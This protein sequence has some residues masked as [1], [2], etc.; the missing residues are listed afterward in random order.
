MLEQL[1]GT[2]PPPPPAD[3]PEL[4]E[5]SSSDGKGQ[6]DELNIRKLL[7]LHREPSA[8]FSCHQKMDPLGIGLENFDATGR[9]RE[10]YGTA[11]ID[12][13]GV[14]PNGD[15]FN[16]PYE[17]RLL[18]LKKKELFARNLSRKMLSFALGR[19]VRFQ[20]KRTVD[21][22]ARTLLANDFASTPFLHAVVTSY[23]FRYKKSDLQIEETAP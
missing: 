14:M 8:C 19:G 16:G 17:L 6:D 1:L 3:V 11:P 22:L 7:R 2:P 15:H 4:E 13:S 10:A 18:L 9:W 12:A 5:Q 20:D 21:D 23:P